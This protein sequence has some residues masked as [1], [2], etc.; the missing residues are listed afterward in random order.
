MEIETNRFRLRIEEKVVGYQKQ[1][2]KSCFFST[3][4]YSWNGSPIMHQI[5]DEFSGFFDKNN[6]AIYAQD[7]VEIS[8]NP[9]LKFGLVL[10][11]EL[12]QKFQIF[13][14]ENEEIQYKPIEEILFK[15]EFVIKSHYFIQP[16]V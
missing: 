10:F 14:L 11:D 5:K 3:D 12:L 8:K 4:Q 7:I 1:I 2:Y 15:N 13:N 16:K 6:R 9:A